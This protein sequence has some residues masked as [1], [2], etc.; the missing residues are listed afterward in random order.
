MACQNAARVSEH[1][2]HSHD[3][4]VSSDPIVGMIH[5]L[6]GYEEGSNGAGPKVGPQTNG[7]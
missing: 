7:E 6:G 3:A 5:I 2:D 1:H 4:L